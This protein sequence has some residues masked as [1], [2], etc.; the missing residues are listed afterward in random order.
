LLAAGYQCTRNKVLAHLEIIISMKIT[1]LLRMALVVAAAI[2]LRHDATATTVDLGTAADF[3]ILGGTAVTFTPPTTTV[4]GGDVGVSPGTSITGAGAN[5]SQSGGV[6]HNNDAVAAGARADT[7]LAYGS[8]AGALP[9][10]TYLGADNQLGGLTLTAGTY[11]FG[12]ASTANLIG[13]LTLSGPGVF[14]F[15]ATSSLVTASGSSINLIN[16]ADACNI[17]W[18]VGSSATLG[19]G[20]F[21]DGTILAQA[22]ITSAGGSTIAGR[23]LAGTGNVTL[24]GDTIGTDRG[25]QPGEGTGSFHTTGVAGVVAGV[26]DSGSTLLLLSSGLAT[27]FAFRRWCFFAA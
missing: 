25:C 21:F 18:Q 23:L 7:T 12:L 17:I 10:T 8:A 1:S 20:S 16:G 22:S 19:S 24:I 15:Q 2:F 4:I 9:T 27:V 26:P 3:S 5:L 14:I 6:I 11:R 13:T